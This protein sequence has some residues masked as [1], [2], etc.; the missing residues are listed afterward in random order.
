VTA[1]KALLIWLAIIDLAEAITAYEIAAVHHVWGLHTISYFSGMHPW[2]GWSIGLAM[3]AIAG[4]WFH[5][6]PKARFG[7]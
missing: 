6:F 7:W 5:H 1:H 2:L 3:L 4:W